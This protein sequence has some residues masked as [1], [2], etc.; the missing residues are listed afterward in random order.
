[1]HGY[2]NKYGTLSWEIVKLYL[3]KWVSEGPQLV[4]Y[5]EVAVGGLS[6]ITR[7]VVMPDVHRWSSSHTPCVCN[8][9]RWQMF[10]GCLAHSYIVWFSW[11]H[12]VFL[13]GE[14]SREQTQTARCSDGSRTQQLCWDKFMFPS[15]RY[16]RT[17][18]TEFT[19]NVQ[20]MTVVIVM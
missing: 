11:V 9:D 19:V 7:K 1:M 16:S 18:Y 20:W 12:P 2:Y 4:S 14:I 10:E 17:D 6:E 5:C 13:V 3:G 8:W 15:K